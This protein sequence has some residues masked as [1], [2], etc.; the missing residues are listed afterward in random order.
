MWIGVY[1]SA[2]Q[3]IKAAHTCTQFPWNTMYAKLIQA[4]GY[5]WIYYRRG[6]L[7]MKNN[8]D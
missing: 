4:P 7:L 5:V 8:Q 2:L 3:L 1:T 6:G